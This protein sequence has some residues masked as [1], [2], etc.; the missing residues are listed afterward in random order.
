MRIG[1]AGVDDVG[2]VLVVQPALRGV[3]REHGWSGVG[4]CAG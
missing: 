1:R 2:V 3:E 4:L